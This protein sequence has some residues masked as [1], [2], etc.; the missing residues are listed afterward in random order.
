MSLVQAWRTHKENSGL[1][2]LGCHADRLTQKPRRRALW[3][4]E[5]GVP[6]RGVAGWKERRTRVVAARPR[7]R[8]G[9]PTLSAGRR[10]EV[11]VTPGK[12]VAVDTAP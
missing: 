7:G 2:S 1:G 6:E 9:P 4:M 3:C 11:S 10:A 12:A 8:L 5:A